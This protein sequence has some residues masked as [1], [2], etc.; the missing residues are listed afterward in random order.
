[1]NYKK[2]STPLLMTAAATTVTETVA[3]VTAVTPPATS[4]TK[5]TKTDFILH[6]FGIRFKFQEYL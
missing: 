3:R 4:N 1:M 2:K 5:G 6:I